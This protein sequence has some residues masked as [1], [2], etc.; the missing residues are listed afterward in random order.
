MLSQ[1]KRIVRTIYSSPPAD[2]AA[3]AALILADPALRKQ[4]DEELGAMRVRIKQMRALLAEK[5][6]ERMPGRDFSYIVRQNGMFSYSRLTAPQAIALR[7]KYWSMRW[8]AAASAS[9][10]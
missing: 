7:E 2:G 9:R 4:W 3:S 1:L 8:T 10:R 6:A 5:L